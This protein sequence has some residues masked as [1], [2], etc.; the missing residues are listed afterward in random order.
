MSQNSYLDLLDEIFRAAGEYHRRSVPQRK[1]HWRQIRKIVDATG[2]EVGRVQL[3]K[4]TMTTLKSPKN[5]QH[6]YRVN[7]AGWLLE[8]KKHSFSKLGEVRALDD[9]QARIWLQNQG[10][11]VLDQEPG[12]PKVHYTPQDGERIYIQGG[13]VELDTQDARTVSVVAETAKVVVV[14]HQ[15]KWRGSEGSEVERTRGNV[16]EEADA[17]FEL[18]D[19]D[20]AMNDPADLN[21]VNTSGTTLVIEETTVE[22]EI[23]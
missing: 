15:V 7:G 6:L 14:G 20:P 9:A 5:G 8:T 3:K 18:A 12:Q 23:V 13:E 2:Q 11:T 22:T 16:V 10:W 17:E 21:P 1:E 19:A 4:S